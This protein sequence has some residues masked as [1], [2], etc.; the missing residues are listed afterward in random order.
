M[1]NAGA[2]DETGAESWLLCKSSRHGLP[3]CSL[4]PSVCRKPPHEFRAQDKPTLSFLHTLRARSTISVPNT[5]A[6]SAFPVIFTMV[7][8]K[9]FM[10]VTLIS[11]S[12]PV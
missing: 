11:L 4:S 12:T 8:S 9:L 5:R 3:T 6:F 10:W 2:Q 7:S 1:D